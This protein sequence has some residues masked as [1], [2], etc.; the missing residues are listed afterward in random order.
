MVKS[1]LFDFS[2][3]KLSTTNSY[4]NIWKNTQK[5]KSFRHF[6]WHNAQ[7]TA[8]IF[9]NGNTIITD[10]NAFGILHKVHY[11]C[12]KAILNIFI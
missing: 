8:L 10:C 6:L 9:K 2:F 4:K 7:K 5:I 12:R 1:K 11:N 3:F